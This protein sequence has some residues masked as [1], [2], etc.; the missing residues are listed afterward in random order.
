MRAQRLL[1]IL[2]V[3]ALLSSLVPALTNSRASSEQPAQATADAFGRLPLAFEANRGQTAARVKFLSRGVGFNLFLTP[4]EAV[5]ALKGAVTARVVSIHM[6][7]ANPA[8]RI[9]GI[10]R[11][12]G[13]SHYLIGNDPTKWR[14]GVPTYA[15]VLYQ[16][17]YPGID[18]MYYGSQ[19]AL[20][21]DFIVDPGANPD[22]IRLRFEGVDR[23][24][25]TAGG[26]LV[27]WIPEGT[28]R[29][30]K[31][32]IY[33]EVDGRRHE[34]SGSYATLDAH[35]VGFRVAAYDANRPLII[36]PVLVYSTYL[37]GSP[38][39]E[40]LA[41]TADQVGNVYVAGHTFSSN[42]PT[43][44]G[45]FQPGDPSPSDFTAFVT[46]LNANGSGLAFS[47]Y[48]GGSRN[49]RASAIA[50][51]T[52]GNVYVAGT[53]FSYDFPTTPGAVQAV[54]PDFSGTDAFAT[55]LNPSGSA[56]VYSTYLGAGGLDTALGVTVDS[57]AS[58]YV[59]GWT[60]STDFPTTAGS[61]Q[62]AHAGGWS[63]AFVT[64]L[65]SAGSA[66]VYSTLLGGSSGEE[67]GRGIVVDGAGNAY[68][69]GTSW[70]TDF[71]TT[72]NVPQPF[73]P[74]TFAADGFVTKL[75]ATGS[76]LIYST[77]LGGANG[78]DA[79]GIVLDE[80]ASAYVTGYT[81]SYDFPTTSGAF[82]TSQPTA[83]GPDSFVSKLN[84]GGTAL[85]YSTYL[86]GAGFDVSYSI[87]VWRG[88]AHVTGY[89]DSRDFPRTHRRGYQDAYDVFVTKLNA[90]G[91]RLLYSMYF[92]GSG[93]DVGVG[94]AADS[95]G[96][97]YV[98]GWAS[99]LNFPLHRALQ[100]SYGGGESDG[101][102]LKIAPGDD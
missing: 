49:D 38:L 18:L 92:G 89:T 69:A 29:L 13:V 73:D 54:D 96:N 22:Q 30:R 41:I 76:A 53:T 11:L 97:V 4:T 87:A 60:T 78:D 94:I 71:P 37:G 7:R 62:P 91:S 52:S 77:F 66:L 19:R 24:Y 83:G 44:A 8:P 23:T 98:T 26:D 33:Q 47:T 59:I 21:Y 2:V 42:F 5:F 39:D 35:T 28:L 86:G 43:T 72:A 68:V 46:K 64:K 27:A 6:L 101:F 51:D 82:Q 61:F 65:N 25:V 20:E 56:L 70:S 31:P 45:A 102:V 93:N 95:A 1:L 58:A 40:G 75:N 48:L 36:D 15:S 17:I 16:G 3:T 81:E 74:D 79:N 57:A 10:K 85:V 67:R 12:P 63:D 80:T 14:T 88:S 9:A 50:V 34:V 100:S 84:P 55:K 32:V 99:S 90:R